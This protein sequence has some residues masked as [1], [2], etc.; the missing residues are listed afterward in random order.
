[1][2][3]IF[4]GAM[5]LFSSSMFAQSWESVQ[6]L[7]AAADDRHHPISFTIDGVAYLMGGADDAYASM[8]DFYAY[9][10]VDDSW[11]TKADF[12]GL[13]R[14]FAYGCESL[15]ALFQRKT[16]CLLPGY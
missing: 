10:P 12:P 14:G 11:T 7:P 8:D 5:L 9:D 16:Y 2:Q 6:S 4:L 1:M 13:S 15:E 3:K